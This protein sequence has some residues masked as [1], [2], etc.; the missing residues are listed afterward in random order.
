MGSKGPAHQCT[1]LSLCPLLARATLAMWSSPLPSR[2]AHATDLS[3]DTE[4]TPSC[5]GA[6]CFSH[7]RATSYEADGFCEACAPSACRRKEGGRKGSLLSTVRSSR[8]APGTHTK[9]GTPPDSN[10]IIYMKP[11]RACASG[12]SFRIFTCCALHTRAAQRRYG[13]ARTPSTSLPSILT[14][15]LVN[16]TR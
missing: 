10:K 7:Q 5:N 9:E 11:A 13:A 2:S 16:M 12:T 1:R 14:T 3:S 8:P 4:A 15:R 6:R